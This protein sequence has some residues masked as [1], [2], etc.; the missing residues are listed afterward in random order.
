MKC[1]VNESV[2]DRNFEA[3]ID[4]LKDLTGTSNQ[5]KTDVSSTAERTDKCEKDIQKILRELATLTGK[6]DSIRDMQ[7]QSK[8]NKDEEGLTVGRASDADL[9][10][11]L[12]KKIEEEIER[13]K[14]NNLENLKDINLLLRDVKEIKQRL[15]GVDSKVDTS[16]GDG[17]TSAG[18]I[19]SA[20]ELGGG[21]ELEMTRVV[22]NEM[23]RQ[24]ELIN[25]LFAETDSLKNADG[26]LHNKINKLEGILKNTSSNGDTHQS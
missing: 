10:E 20:S 18:R 9:L 16:I 14:K 19:G 21:S 7:P 8:G 3:I 11:E 22:Q 15:D 5:L 25:K 4:C 17:L 26:K 13:N 24:L 1:I 12:R 6:L 2:I 23:Q